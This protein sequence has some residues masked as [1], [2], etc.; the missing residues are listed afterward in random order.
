MQD[1][2][3]DDL[4]YLL[5][6]HRRGT[7][8][9]AGRHLRVSETTVARRVKRLEAH[10]GTALF[11][12]SHS[13]GYE[14]TETGRAVLGQAEKVERHASVL[15]DRLG[16]SAGLSGTVRI[17][18]VPIIVNHVLIPAVPAL[19]AAHPDLSVELVPEARN[20]DLTRR[21]ADL[22]LRFARPGQGGL[23]VKTRKLADWSFGVFCA[24]DIAAG[25]EESLPWI[26]YDDAHAGLPQARWIADLRGPHERL[27]PLRVSDL[28]STLEAVVL[29]QG[30][31][32]LPLSLGRGDPRLR[33]AVHRRSGPAMSRA[34]WLLW[35]ADHPGPAAIAAARDW[36]CGIDW[37]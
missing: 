13:G 1:F 12:R 32:V 24:A 21:E 5:A 31:S 37:R 4:R 33:A 22:A 29:R 19:S 34:V 11:V 28:S 14:L 36:I 15:Q 35:H 6:L 9:E 25:D 10:L 26:G 7:L 23:A 30:K 2:D 27:S 16:T 8:A 3:W 17:S 18:A 20:L